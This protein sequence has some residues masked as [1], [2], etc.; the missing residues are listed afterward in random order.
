LA[1][2]YVTEA[3]TLPML[4]PMQRSIPTPITEV[5][6]LKAIILGCALCAGAGGTVLWVKAGGNG[7]ANV[8]AATAAVSPIS[9]QELHSNAHLD[10]LPIQVVEDPY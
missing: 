2:T 9:I 4:S 7:T 6:M 1:V 10:N 8:T 3:E 5:P